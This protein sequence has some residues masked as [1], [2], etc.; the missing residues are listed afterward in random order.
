MTYQICLTCRLAWTGPAGDS[1]CGAVAL[2]C[3]PFG[4]DRL[5][6]FRARM[7]E[8]PWRAAAVSQLA[9]LTDRAEVRALLFAGCE[10]RG[11]SVAIGV[12]L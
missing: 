6:W 4:G 3:D 11:R 1:C 10:R 2:T 7:S 5:V 12:A 9:H 8:R